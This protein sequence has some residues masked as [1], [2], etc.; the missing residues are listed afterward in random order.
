MLPFLRIANV[1][2]TLGATI[3][4]ESLDVEILRVLN[5]QLKYHSLMALDLTNLPQE[6]TSFLQ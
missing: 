5:S 2:F 6:L 4:L 3:P 1:D